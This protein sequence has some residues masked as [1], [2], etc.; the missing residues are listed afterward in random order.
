MKQLR[1]VGEGDGEGE[2]LH[3]AVSSS[4]LGLIIVWLELREL[5]PS[6]CGTINREETESNTN[7]IKWGTY[8]E[9][10]LVREVVGGG[11]GDSPT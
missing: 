4:R 9:L 2:V 10:E 1:S 6:E 8:S 7:S 5:L 3:Q 11:A